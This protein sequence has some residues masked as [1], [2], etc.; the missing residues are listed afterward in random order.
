MKILLILVFFA[1][2]AGIILRSLRSRGI[3]NPP[4]TTIDE[5]P[6][7]VSLLERQAIDH[8]FIVFLFNLPGNNDESMPN[9][10]YSV[11]NRRVGLD[12][13]LEA[14]QNIKDETAL[15]DFIKRNGYIV[16][17]ND[18][19]DVHYLRVEGEGIANLGVKIL[20][21]FY[22]LPPDTKLELIVE[23]VFRE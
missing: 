12:W 19:E 7:L 10:Q 23:G 6:S 13:V 22:H 15:A 1:I 3:Q 11:E 9:L 21:E 17:K 8:T 14:P 18:M 16:S 4:S 2:L 5:I 20:R